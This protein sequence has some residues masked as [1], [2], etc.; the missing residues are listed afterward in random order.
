MTT[1]HCEYAQKIIFN[2]IPVLKNQTG[3]EFE[4]KKSKI[5]QKQLSVIKE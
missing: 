1:D 4:Y 3:T 5:N 2:E